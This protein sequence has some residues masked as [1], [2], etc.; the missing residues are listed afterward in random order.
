MIQNKRRAIVLEEKIMLSRLELITL[1][2]RTLV[3]LF[4]LYGAY[5][6]GYG[7]PTE[8]WRKETPGGVVARYTRNG[9]PWRIF[10][11]RDRDRKWDMWIDE[12]AGTP[13]IVSIDD[14]RDGS[15]DRDEDEFG[16]RLSSWQ[17]A[18]IRARKTFSDFVRNPRQWQYAGLALMLYTMLELII[19]SGRK[20]G[21]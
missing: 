6:F 10:Y 12:R 13:F 18:G 20:M 8:E 21:T 9:R 3:L 17:G 1:P 15:P 7:T 5:Y 4:L 2:I 16:N 14:N 19:R 11:D